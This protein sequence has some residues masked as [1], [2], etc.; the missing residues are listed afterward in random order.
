MS[1]AANATQYYRIHITEADKRAIDWLAENTPISRMQLKKALNNGAVWLKQGKK[2]ER[3]RRATREL[4]VG[5]TLELHYNA[6]IMAQ[7][8]P[9]LTVVDHQKSYTVFFKPAGVLSQ[10]SPEGDHMSALRIAE[11]QTGR[12]TYLIHRLDR[13][14]SGLLIIGHSEKAA[15]LLS[16]MFQK[17]EINKRYLVAVKGEWQPELPLVLDNDIDGKNAVTVIEQAR[18]DAG[19]DQ[20]YL[21]LTIETGRQHQ[22]RRHLAEAGYPVIGD[23]RYGKRESG[24]TLKLQAFEL[25]YL[26]P[27]ANRLRHYTVPADLA[28]N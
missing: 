2:Q 20:T 24:E 17:R 18:Y 23:W 5:S 8:P 26:C 28:L 7:T 19:N 15:A 11:Q 10:G 4:P 12:K 22:I 6:E 9:L 21:R 25:E 14:A 3:M 27:L 16:Q 1:Q 13:E